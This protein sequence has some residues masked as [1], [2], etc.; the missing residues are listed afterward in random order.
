MATLEIRGVRKT[1]GGVVALAGVDVTVRSE[2]RAFHSFSSS[3]FSVL[4]GR[5]LSVRAGIGR[6]KIILG[7][8]L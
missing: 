8:N 1:F 4:M 7:M 6:E 3:F 2:E 5:S